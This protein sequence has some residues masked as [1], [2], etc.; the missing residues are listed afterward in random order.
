MRSLV[1]TLALCSIAPWLAASATSPAAAQQVCRQK[2]MDEEN[3]CLKRTFNKS[4]CG[5]KASACMAKCK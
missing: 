3:A 4:Q 1:L 5:G 2:C